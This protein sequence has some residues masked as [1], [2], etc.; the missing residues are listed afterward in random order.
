MLKSYNY[1]LKDNPK[2]NSDYNKYIKYSDNSNFSSGL[3]C[4]CMNSPLYDKIDQDKINESNIYFMDKACNNGVSNHNSYETKTIFE[5]KNANSISICDV[6]LGNNADA[7]KLNITD[8]YINCTNKIT[9][10]ITGS[11][12]GSNSGSGAKKI[13]DS[14]AKKIEDSGAKKI[15]DSGAKKIEDPE[16]KKIEDPEA[17]KNSFSTNEIIG[18]VISL[19]FLIIFLFLIYKYF[20]NKKR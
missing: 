11:S 9:N 13:E 2:L 10:N 19:I 18:I 8:N 20:K 17:N 6:N 15:E 12:S 1:D 14:G 4:S 16:A 7:L 3:E 5:T